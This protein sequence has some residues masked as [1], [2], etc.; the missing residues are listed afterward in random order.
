MVSSPVFESRTLL[1]VCVVLS[2]DHICSMTDVTLLRNW[3]TDFLRLRSVLGHDAVEQD[4][5]R[6]GLDKPFVHRVEAA[7]R[8]GNQQAKNKRGQRC[9]HPRP[10]LYDIL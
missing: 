7:L 8:G 6:A 4:D 2:S 3:L 9:D 1:S 10:H 5:F